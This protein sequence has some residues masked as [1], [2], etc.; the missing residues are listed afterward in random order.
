[1][2][3]GFMQLQESGRNCPMALARVDSTL[4]KK[5]TI[6]PGH[7]R[8]NDDQ[9]IFVLDIIAVGTDEPLPIVTRGY[10]PHTGAGAINGF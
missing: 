8:A 7:H 5:E 3:G 10:G 4:A 9:R 6:L 1:M 2:R